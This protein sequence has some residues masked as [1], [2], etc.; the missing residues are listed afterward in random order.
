MSICNVAKLHE[1]WNL[2]LSLLI[3]TPRWR[4]GV[5]STGFLISNLHDIWIL[6][7]ISMT[8]L[9]DL[10]HLQTHLSLLTPTQGWRTGAIL[11]E[12]MM[13]NLQDEEERESNS[14]LSG[15]RELYEDDY[16]DY[17]D[18]GMTTILPWWAR[19]NSH[20]RRRKKK[21]KK[22]RKKRFSFWYDLLL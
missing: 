16:G 3:L 2:H 1:I 20:G 17:G 6:F 13:S 18:T 9:M 11:T 21:K 4:T 7:N 8:F 12:I 5:T 19:T 15:R 10:D 14:L 22:R